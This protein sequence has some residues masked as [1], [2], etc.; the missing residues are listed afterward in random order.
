VSKSALEEH[1]DGLLDRFDAAEDEPPPPVRPLP[2]AEAVIYA[3]V[4]LAI[5]VA[6]IGALLNLVGVVDLSQLL[7]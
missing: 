3:V 4:A 7:S 6:A 5:V 2:R 1:W